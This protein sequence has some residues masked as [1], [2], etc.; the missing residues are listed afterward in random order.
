MSK[1]IS[2]TMRSVQE[3]PPLPPLQIASSSKTFADAAGEVNGLTPRQVAAFK[4][5]SLQQLEVR[6]K[7]ERE[8]LQR[9]QT[10]ELQLLMQRQRQ[11]SQQRSQHFTHCTDAGT[12]SAHDEAHELLDFVMKSLA[13]APP[14]R[15]RDTVQALI[16]WH[17]ALSPP[18]QPTSQQHHG[19][20]P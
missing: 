6:Q 20:T 1:V 9:K 14:G 2:T 11:K 4:T 7:A 13:R 5:S 16:A 15:E 8:D 10:A 3:Y 19:P 18:V 17:R 12:T